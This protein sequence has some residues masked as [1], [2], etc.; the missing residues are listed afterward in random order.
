MKI[1]SIVRLLYSRYLDESYDHAMMRTKLIPVHFNAS[2][3]PGSRIFIIAK[4]KNGDNFILCVLTDDNRMG[5]L[6]YM[7]DSQC[8]NVAG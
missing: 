3:L 2:I 6:S 7:C 8:V 1:G 5:W 4:I